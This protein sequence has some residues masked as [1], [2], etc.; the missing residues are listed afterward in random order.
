MARIPAKRPPTPRP[1]AQPPKRPMP[2]VKPMAG[3]RAPSLPANL[4]QWTQSR[5]NRDR[6]EPGKYN[7]LYANPPWR[8]VS[9]WALWVNRFI[10]W[11]RNERGKYNIIYC[12]PPW[13]Y[14][15][16][17]MSELAERGEKWARR[18]GRSPYDVMLTGDIGALPAGDLAAKDSLLFMWVTDPKLEESFEVM[19]AWGFNFVTV[20][21]YWVKQ[22][23]SGMGFHLGLG[24]HTRANP[25]QCLIGKRGK[26]LRRVDNSVPRL[27][28]EP[29]GEHS[30]KPHEAR[31]RI[32]RL[33]GDVPRIELFA[34][35][36]HEGWDIWGNQAPGGS[37][38]ELG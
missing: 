32:A 33:Y 28:I 10:N 7:I 2:D 30:K 24:Y 16:W 4:A 35:Q 26:G 6:V 20:G 14:K 25:E 38:V 13:R 8:K 34:R 21:F 18:N 23:P 19:S 9:R 3:D 22:N 12:D 27:M 36:R 17:S 15:N 29:V 31:L 5:L 37:D 11:L 1:K